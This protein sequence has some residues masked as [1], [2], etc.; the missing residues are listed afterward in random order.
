MKNVNRSV[1]IPQLQEP[2]LEK[3]SPSTV[4]RAYENASHHFPNCTNIN[5]VFLE[6]TQETQKF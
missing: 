3:L 2:S 1:L 6:V 5:Q 4:K